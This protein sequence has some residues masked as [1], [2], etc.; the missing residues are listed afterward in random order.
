MSRATVEVDLN[1]R[2][3]HGLTPVRCDKASAPLHV[4]QIVTAVERED[5]VQ[6]RAY[7]AEIDARSG[8]AFLHIDTNS[9]TDLGDPSFEVQANCGV[10]RAVASVRNTA[11]AS[12]SASGRARA[13][14]YFNV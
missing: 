7:V 2:D 1:S 3:A 6:A 4:G 10:N 5:E 11:A 12:S 8:Y 14:M 13:S 9:M